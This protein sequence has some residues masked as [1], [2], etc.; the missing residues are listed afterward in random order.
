[1]Q[2]LIVGVVVGHVRGVLE[3]LVPGQERLRAQLRQHTGS[4]ECGNEMLA[5][6]L[7]ELPGADPVSAAQVDEGAGADRL[8]WGC[9][10]VPA[11]LPWQ[12]PIEQGAAEDVD[13]VLVRQ[14]CLLTPTQWREGR[15]EGDFRDSVDLSVGGDRGF[16]PVDRWPPAGVLPREV[17]LPVLLQAWSGGL[18]SGPCRSGGAGRC[19]STAGSRR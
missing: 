7:P 4:D 6:E 3:L 1:M 5:D 17:D 10:V 11:G 13:L 14:A 2:A 12:A 18:S 19:A 9:D 8:P 16:D 15:L